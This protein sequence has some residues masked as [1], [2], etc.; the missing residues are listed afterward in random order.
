MREEGKHN[1]KNIAHALLLHHLI[2]TI[3]AVFSR[4]F[5][6]MSVRALFH[7]YRSKSDSAEIILDKVFCLRTEGGLCSAVLRHL[8]GNSLENIYSRYL[9]HLIYCKRKTKKMTG[10]DS[11][12]DKY[13]WD[14]WYY[15]F[16]WLICLGLLLFCQ[17]WSSI[18]NVLW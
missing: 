7:Q 4:I 15:V 3:S 13:L 10:S 16:Q 12:W 8:A 18:P 17:T 11:H 6:L 9:Q 2:W 14:L 5:L 1:G